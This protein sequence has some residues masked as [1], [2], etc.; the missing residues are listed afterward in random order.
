MK[1]FYE[2][3]HN[4]FAHRSDCNQNTARSYV[5]QVHFGIQGLLFGQGGSFFGIQKAENPHKK[6]A[7][8][9]KYPDKE[10]KRH[11]HRS[12]GRAIIKHAFT[13]G[14]KLGDPTPD[15]Q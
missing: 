8:Y 6:I 7:E 3:S 12:T 14:D 1:D 10:H 13:P 11:P 4:T 15:C 5:V 2:D 9:R